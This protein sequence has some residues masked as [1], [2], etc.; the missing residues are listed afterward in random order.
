MSLKG[1]DVSSWNGQPFDGKTEA[2][3][4]KSSFVIAKATQGTGYVNSACDYAIER[5]KKAG[6]LWGFYHYAAG[7]SAKKEAEYFYAKTRGYTKKGIPCLDWES[8]DNPAFGNGSWVK[9]F[10][11]RYHALTGVWPLIYVQ[12][13]AVGQIPAYV[14]KRCGLWIAGYPTNA[15][16]WSVPGF[17]F[18]TGKWKAATIWQFSSGG[19]IDRNVG[20]LSKNA[21]HKIAGRTWYKDKNGNYRYYAPRKMTNPKRCKVYRIKHGKKT[22]VRW[23]KA[24]CTWNVDMVGSKKKWARTKYGNYAHYSDLKKK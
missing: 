7:G 23:A 5:A 24:G 20:Y 17:A 3:L 9:A 15:D 18:S 14:A 12:A 16:S 22:F 11:K 10:A 19:G 4:S 21:W 1:I 13:S 6:M 8:G 2:A